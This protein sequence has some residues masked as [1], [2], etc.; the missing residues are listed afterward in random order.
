MQFWLDMGAS[1]FRV[2]MAASL[3]K[4]DP[5]SRMNI[6]LWQDIRGWMEARYPEAILMSEWSYPERSIRAG[7]HI[8]FYIHFGGTGYTSLFRK[9]TGRGFGMN[10]Y[11]FS[12]FSKDGLGNIMEF[13]DDFRR[14][15]E[16]SRQ[17][18]YICIPTG[19]HDIHPRLG[20]DRDF[21][22]L[23]VAFTFIMTMPGVPK[24]YY[25]DEIGMQGVQGLPS[26][27]GGYERTEVRTPM[28]WSHQQNAGFSNGSA[29]DLYL[30]VEPDLGQRTVEDQQKDPDSLLSQVQKLAQLRRAHPALCNAAEFSVLYAVGGSYP[31][32]YLRRGDGESIV[33]AVNPSNRPVEVEFPA[34][35]GATGTVTDLFGVSGGLSKT[36]HGWK[37]TLPAISA[38]VWKI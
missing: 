2:D 13:V 12:F 37:V 15:Y 8:D 20:R 14:Q 9:N 24:I 22:D 16:A 19:N 35:D 21:K 32:V 4:N 38:G 5:G 3:V 26:R 7:F 36:D 6:K 18:G 25:G 23:L 34:I 11:A 28:Q 30:P 17:N 1:G 33:V 29:E 10:P 31:F 27:E